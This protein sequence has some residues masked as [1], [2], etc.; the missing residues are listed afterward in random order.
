MRGVLIAL[1]LPARSTAPFCD[2]S[3]P[4]LPM[5][6]RPLLQHAVDR[7]VGEGVRDLHVIAGGRSRS[8]EAFLGDGARWGCSFRVHLV[9]DPRHPYRALRR[10]LEPG[11]DGSC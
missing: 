5:V 6:G 3:L 10:I 4:L 8:I 9:R 7:M 11:D 2:L 1:D